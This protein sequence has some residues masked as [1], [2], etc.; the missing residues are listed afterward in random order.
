MSNKS[1][2]Q[3]DVI[4]PY[5][6]GTNDAATTAITIFD[7]IIA[8]N[9]GDGYKKD[10][11]YASNL[12][13]RLDQLAKKLD[14]T[15]R[16]N[17]LAAL[18]IAMITRSD[19]V[20]TEVTEFVQALTAQYFEKETHAARHGI[21]RRVSA[22]EQLDNFLAAGL[23]EHLASARRRVHKPTAYDAAQLTLF[24]QQLLAQLFRDDLVTAP[25]ATRFPE[26]LR[27]LLTAVYDT[28]LA[29]QTA[30]DDADIDD[31]HE[32][33]RIAVSHV[34]FQQILPSY[35][36][37]IPGKVKTADGNRVAVPTTDK[38]GALKTAD[39]ARQLQIMLATF[40]HMHSLT[41][42]A[43][44]EG[45]AANL[46]ASLHHAMTFVGRPATN[47]SGVSP[48]QRGA[49]EDKPNRA[50]DGFNNVTL[51]TPLANAADELQAAEADYNR[52]PAE[53]V[54]AN[55]LVA[56]GR[57][58]LQAMAKAAGTA[59]DD[60]L[61]VADPNK[62]KKQGRRQQVAKA[63]VL[64]ARAIDLVQT[65]SDDDQARAVLRNGL[66]TIISEI[67]GTVGW[68]NS[69]FLRQVMQVYCALGYS[70]N[71]FA[72][73]AEFP[74]PAGK[75]KYR[76]KLANIDFTANNLGVSINP[77]LGAGFGS[78][79]VLAFATGGF[80]TYLA[81]ADAKKRRYS[82]YHTN[83]RKTGAAAAI[84]ADLAP[85]AQA[86][87][88]EDADP[89]D[90]NFVLATAMGLVEHSVGAHTA[91]ITEGGTEVNQGKFTRSHEMFGLFSVAY[92]AAQAANVALVAST[93][94]GA[95]AAA[96]G[97][98]VVPPEETALTEAAEKFAAHAK[99]FTFKSR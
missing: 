97:A 94:A 1:T 58:H 12:K 20:T 52:L 50:G 19:A 15:Q 57:Y 29:R 86:L 71:V 65:H 80:E 59:A 2:F 21:T 66:Q 78:R 99:N 5:V 4:N 83:P 90:P 47:T 89:S 98:A 54:A 48:I 73:A 46:A 33:A 24:G 62:Q 23:S 25:G 82:V 32:Q 7:G 88:S 76:D 53:T 41:Q 30:A 55:L 34:L 61:D 63:E 44:V 37:A 17:L 10:L 85:V 39:D 49:A 68:K 28:E 93:G 14:S 79:Y 31:A 11:Y 16:A 92:Q 40:D 72:D 64:A 13:N 22:A 43:V 9:A 38:K 45:E 96:G 95:G 3:N 84:E 77:E 67:V 56:C 74:L 81:V 75:E 51:P 26:A 87:A 27:T 36:E 69:H 6:N 42:L 60:D 91:S 18:H 8:A 35:V 70:S